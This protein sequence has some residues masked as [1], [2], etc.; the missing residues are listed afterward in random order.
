M[1]ALTST[2]VNVNP[3]EFQGLRGTQGNIGTLLDIN[4]TE[5]YK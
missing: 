2:T 1:E 5:Q 3:D 4:L